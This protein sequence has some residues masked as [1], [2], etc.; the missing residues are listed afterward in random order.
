MPDRL[1][2]S[3]RPEQTTPGPARVP[4]RRR[5]HRVEPHSASALDPLGPW[6]DLLT[7]LGCG[8]AGLTTGEA[9]RRLD[10]TGP[11]VLRAND[12]SGLLLPLVRQLT[13]PLALLLWMAAVLAFA[14]QGT[15]LGIA[16][17]GVIGLN[18]FFAIVQERHA[19][20]AVA[21][22]SRYLPQHAVV[23]R[24]GT[25]SVVAAGD[26]VPGDLLVV[27]EVTRSAQTPGFSTAQSRWTSRRSTANRS[28][29]AGWFQGPLPPGRTGSPT[30]RT[31]SSPERR[32]QRARHG[33]S[34]R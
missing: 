26:V 4:E 1:T 3:R 23:V 5:I 28:R 16:I 20:H 9:R 7:G 31:C 11:N 18:A 24:D 19:E 27:R 29:S 13:H 22:L 32:A 34:S 10:V 33:H 12:R 15:T 21:A 25:N 14:T 2:I 6:D 30:P 17:V 8:T